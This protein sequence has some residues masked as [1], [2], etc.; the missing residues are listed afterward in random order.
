MH[1]STFT[2]ISI[3]IPS[4]ILSNS[5]GYHLFGYFLHNLSKGANISL[6][7][8]KSIYI[9]NPLDSLKLKNSQKDPQTINSSIFL[10]Y[11]QCRSR[12]DFSF[13]PLYKKCISNPF[14]PTFSLN[15]STFEPSKLYSSRSRYLFVRIHSMD[16]NDCICVSWID[17]LF[18]ECHDP[19]VFSEKSRLKLLEKVWLKTISYL[20]PEYGWHVVITYN[21]LINRTEL[22]SWKTLW[23]TFYDYCNSSNASEDLN[24]SP[25]VSSYASSASTPVESNFEI[26]LSQIDQLSV[27]TVNSNDLIISSTPDTW[28]NWYKNNVSDLKNEN[29]CGWIYMSNHP[30]PVGSILPVCSGYI[31]P[32]GDRIN[33]MIGWDMKKRLIHSCFGIGGLKWTRDLIRGGFV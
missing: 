6:K 20:D 2:I 5:D 8:L 19:L 10:I 33:V 21:N 18:E 32:S 3:F 22:N 31:L 24:L 23:H 7:T 4:N 29:P 14:E 17:S 28:L 12:P 27:I 16:Y 15:C 13:S 25:S 1:V 26:P 30:I 9:Y 11:S